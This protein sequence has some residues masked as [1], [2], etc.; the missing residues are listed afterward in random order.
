MNTPRSNAFQSILRRNILLPLGLTVALCASFIGLVSYLLSVSQWVDHSDRILS[1]ANETMKLV[2]DSE[3]GLR[4]FLLSHNEWYL[5]PYR[6]AQV[7]IKT[8]FEK[9][10][11]LSGDNSGQLVHL[12]KAAASYDEWYRL[13]QKTIE[14]DQEKK[15]RISLP[16]LA[17]RR[18]IMDGIRSSFGEY[19]TNEEVNRTTRSEESQARAKQLM[20]GTTLFCFVVGGLLAMAGRNQLLSLS[21]VYEDVLGKQEEQHRRLA[22]QAWIREGKIKTLERIRGELDPSELGSRML[23]MLANYVHSTVGALYTA[24]DHSTVELSATYAGPTSKAP[25]ARSEFRLGE[26]L[27]GQVAADRKPITLD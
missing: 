25:E 24:T 3:T 1:A 26:G 14:D 9:L 12:N 2:V 23:E 17:T 19:I 11:R 22:S 27:V 4:G 16:E 10:R 6:A 15:L 13:A 7:P 8:N 18:Q 5:D 21:K 20:L